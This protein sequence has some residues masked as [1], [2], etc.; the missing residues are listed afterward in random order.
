MPNLT[1]RPASVFLLAGC[2]A[3]AIAVAALVVPA[4][5]VT[6]AQVPG[7][8]V[9]LQVV[10]RGGVDGDAS[11]VVLNVA[12]VRASSRGHVRVWPC[13]EDRPT[14][15]TLNFQAGAGDF[16]CDGGGCR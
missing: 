6:A 11:A 10:G 14:A 7:G 4:A 2:V 15:T 9:E 5:G 8:V 3:A 16:E 12:A 13:G 1:V